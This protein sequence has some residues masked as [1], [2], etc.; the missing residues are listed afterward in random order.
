ML[1]LVS[2]EDRRAGFFSGTVGEV[3]VAGG[4][5]GFDWNWKSISVTPNSL[6]AGGTS[7]GCWGLRRL[8]VG[9]DNALVRILSLLPG[10]GDGIPLLLADFITSPRRSLDGGALVR[11]LGGAVVPLPLSAK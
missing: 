6:L 11:S 1:T 2:K 7:G 5:E 4:V 8:R 3:V 9:E 10:E